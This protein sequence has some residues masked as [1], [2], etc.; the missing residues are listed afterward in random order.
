MKIHSFIWLDDI[1]QKLIWKHSVSQDE[2]LELFV[3]SPRFR[4][5]EKGDRIGENVYSAS[6]QTDGGKYLIA[7][8]VLKPGNAA[9]IL[10]VREMSR[11]ERKK[12]ERK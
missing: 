5:V 6:G 2:V 1:V 12:Y 11:A 7:F 9:L 10:S 4:F 3:N 8:F